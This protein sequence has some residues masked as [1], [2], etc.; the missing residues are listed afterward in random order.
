MNNKTLKKN[1]TIC[2]NRKRQYEFDYSN[3][4]EKLFHR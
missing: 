3:G 4:T 2:P 1:C